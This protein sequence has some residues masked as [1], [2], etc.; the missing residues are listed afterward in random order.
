[1]NEGWKKRRT[2][3]KKNK[4]MQKRSQEVVKIQS[5]ISFVLWHIFLE[6]LS[7]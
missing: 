5:E 4:G 1:M 2:N 3:E 7:S 6:Q